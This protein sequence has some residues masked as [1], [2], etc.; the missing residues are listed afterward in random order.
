MGLQGFY[1]RFNFRGEL[2]GGMDIVTQVYG[3]DKAKKYKAYRTLMTISDGPHSGHKL[4]EVYASGR[5]R[6]VRNPPP[7]RAA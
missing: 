6:K 1:F 7:S 5:P 3:E 4:S 2:V